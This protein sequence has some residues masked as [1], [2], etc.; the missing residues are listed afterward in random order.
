MIAFINDNPEGLSD[1]ISVLSR[2]FESSTPEGREYIKLTDFIADEDRDEA[3]TTL[4]VSFVRDFDLVVQRITDAWGEPNF[5]GSYEEPGYPEKLWLSPHF[6]YWI[7][8]DNVG[9]V[10]CDHQDNELPVEL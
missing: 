5:N 9:Y 7:R 4:W 3:R 1:P 10:V 6:A 2:L 8:G